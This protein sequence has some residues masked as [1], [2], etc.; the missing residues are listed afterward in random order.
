MSEAQPLVSVMIPAYNAERFIAEAVG[1]I[2]KQGYEP[3]EIV[4]ADDGSTDRT[5]EVVAGLT[6]PVRYVRQENAGPPAAR[7][8]AIREATGS[9]FGFLDA[10]DMWAEDK[11]R[12][13]LP[14]LAA[15]PEVGLVCG[16]VQIFLDHGWDGSRHHLEPYQ[17]PKTA[18]TLQGSLIQRWVFDRVGLFRE[19]QRY[20]DDVE[21]FLRVRELGIPIL[22]HPE[23]TF[24][25]RRHDRNIT[26]Q[27]GDHQEYLARLLKSSLDRRRS[28]S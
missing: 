7:N 4:V 19:D 18:L 14:L 11:L 17:D 3:A 12:V 10:D 15:H 2:R 5:P 21:W 16:R 9:V 25:Y 20:A 27:A 13:Q 24:H 6:P 8:R 22:Q 26:N 28:R 1:S 23:I